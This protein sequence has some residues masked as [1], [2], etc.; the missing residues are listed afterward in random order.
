MDLLGY[1]QGNLVPYQLSDDR[2][3]KCN[4]K[5]LRPTQIQP[6]E[7]YVQSWNQVGD[8][9]DR[10]VEQNNGAVQL[11]S[12]KALFRK[13]FKMELS[14]SALGHAKLSE[15]VQD[16]RLRS[17]SGGCFGLEQCGTQCHLVQKKCTT[18][19]EPMYV[20]ISG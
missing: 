10:L 1:Y 3:K 19:E 5:M 18:P 17:P 13:V 8:L 15:F 11:S 9:L 14:E 20:A 12:L 4:A 7:Q 2:K 16:P 6:G